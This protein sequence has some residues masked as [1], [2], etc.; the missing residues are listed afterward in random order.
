M[1]TDNLTDLIELL[2]EYE[3]IEPDP[4]LEDGQVLAPDGTIVTL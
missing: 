1:A 3:D 4:R 2:A